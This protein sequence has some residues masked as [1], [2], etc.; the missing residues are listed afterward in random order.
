MIRL[1]SPQVSLNDYLRG[2][3]KHEPQMIVLFFEKA[4]GTV[5]FS[6][7]MASKIDVSMTQAG[8]LSS[9]HIIGPYQQF[10]FQL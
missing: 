10:S 8:D 3:T 9:R 1:N 7:L 6:R 2:A 5:P 4:V